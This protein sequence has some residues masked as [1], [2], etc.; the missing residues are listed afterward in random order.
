MVGGGKRLRQIDQQDI[1]LR[2]TWSGRTAQHGVDARC[3]YSQVPVAHKRGTIEGNV[4][5]GIRSSSPHLER[6]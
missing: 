6:S 1:G 3:E 4:S 2:P 5:T